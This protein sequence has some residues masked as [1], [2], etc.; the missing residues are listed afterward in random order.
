MRERERELYKYKRIA[1]ESVIVSGL[2]DVTCF[3]NIVHASLQSDWIVRLSHKGMLTSRVLQVKDR[4]HTAIS[5]GVMHS[6]A[7]FLSFQVVICT[8]PDLPV[9]SVGKHFNKDSTRWV[10]TSQWMGCTVY[11]AATRQRKL[12]HLYN[13]SRYC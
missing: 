10:Y 13:A 2:T 3:T 8:L 7:E 6:I 11:Y 1:T 4:D 9:H 12:T 5:Q